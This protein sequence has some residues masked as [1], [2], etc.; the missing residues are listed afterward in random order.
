MTHTPISS[1]ELE[2]FGQ[3]T[4]GCAGVVHLNNAGSALPPDI[5]VDTVVAYLREEALTGG[6]ETEARYADQLE[7]VYQWIARLIGA[8]QDE[9]ALCENA[10]IA[11]LTAFKGL[12]LK[13][14]DEIITSELE[15]TT[16]FIALTDA[17]KAGVKVIVINNDEHGNFPL[18]ALEAAIGPR[19]QLIAVTHIPSSGG[20]MLPVEAIGRIARQKGVLYLLDACQ[21]IGQ[22]PLD[23]G[24]IGCDLLSST[25]RKYLR[26]PRGTGFLYVRKAVQDRIRPFLLDTH[27][28]TRLSPDGYTLRPGA[29]RFELYEKSRALTLGLGKAAEYALT[30]GIDRI[31]ARVQQLAG[32]ARTEL[33]RIPGV[34]IHDTGDRQCGIV[35]FSADHCD[36]KKLCHALMEKGIQVS[37]SAAAATPIYMDRRHLQG[38][39]RASLHYYNTEAEIMQLVDSLAA[40]LGAPSFH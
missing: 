3:D 17:R 27:A 4:S 12:S 22:T 40:L 10:S 7:G 33:R 26:G 30:V 37:Y 6:Y 38:V 21:S 8:D 19:T 28:I 39:V 13:P 5:V 34:T 29:K 24:A 20:G 2:R 15:Y 31:W 11:W 36:T 32:Y 9:I 18:G 1:S 35:T 23:V 16:S 25:G 14:G